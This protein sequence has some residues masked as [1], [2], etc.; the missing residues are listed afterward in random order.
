MDLEEGGDKDQAK[1]EYHKTRMQEK[2]L[3][4]FPCAFQSYCLEEVEAL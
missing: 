3:Y 4:P 1:E 2:E